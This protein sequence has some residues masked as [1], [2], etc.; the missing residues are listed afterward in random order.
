MR[1]SAESTGENTGITTVKFNQ[2][3]YQKEVNMLQNIDVSP[4]SSINRFHSF[5]NKSSSLD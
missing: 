4:I 2:G 3:R 5:G 1:F